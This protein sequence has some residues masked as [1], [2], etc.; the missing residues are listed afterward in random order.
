L[1]K[2]LDKNPKPKAQNPKRK[3]KIQKKEIQ[4]RNPK[5]KAQSAKLKAQ[6]MN[7]I[8]FGVAPYPTW[9]WGKIQNGN[10][11]LKIFKLKIND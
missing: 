9:Y 5:E 3:F 4:K 6:P 7:H 10:L 2:G 11:K 8:G 1:V